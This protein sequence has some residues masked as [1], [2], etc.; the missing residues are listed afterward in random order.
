MVTVRDQNG[1]W[2]LD[3]LVLAVVDVHIEDVD[4]LVLDGLQ[5]L[6]HV[7]D[8]PEFHI[9]VDVAGP[10]D[11]D[12]FQW[13]QEP[14]G[15]DDEQERE[16]RGLIEA[17][18]DH[19]PEAGGGPETGRGGEALDLL[20]VRGDDRTGAE[21]TDAVDDL[22]AEPGDVCLEADGL[23]HGRPVRGQHDILILAE[24]HR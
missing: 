11:D 19:E 23:R 5:D 14:H 21:E 16:K 13:P 2:F 22:R 24:D 10:L 1:V 17:R 9:D 20:L 8:G 15:D 12:L 7:G 3:D 4:V 6:A 18:P